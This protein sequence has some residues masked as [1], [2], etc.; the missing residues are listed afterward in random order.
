ML[1]LVTSHVLVIIRSRKN[2]GSAECQHNI[3][4]SV[5]FFD[6][7]LQILTQEI[8]GGQ[9]LSLILPPNAFR[10]RNFGFRFCIF[11]RNFL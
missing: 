7:R 8:M 9:K 2:V 1:H 11:G 5:Q 10:I 6:R 4:P 3:Q